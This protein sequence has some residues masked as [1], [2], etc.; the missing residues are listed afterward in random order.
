MHLFSSLQGITLMGVIIRPDE[1]IKLFKPLYVSLNRCGYSMLKSTNRL[2]VKAVLGQTFSNYYFIYLCMYI[3][4]QWLSDPLCAM[5]FCMI[6]SNILDII[7]LLKQTFFDNF[8]LQRRKYVYP[9]NIS[10]NAGIVVIKYAFMYYD[11]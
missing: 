6:S 11:E 2:S 9:E 8:L 4:Q 3:T 5:R 7:I 1:G 10:M